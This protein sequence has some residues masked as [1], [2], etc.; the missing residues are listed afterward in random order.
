MSVITIT[1]PG[2]VIN[3]EYY[4]ILKALKDAGIEV[5]EVNV[6]AYETPDEAD[7]HVAII[8]DRLRS[9]DIKSWSVQ[10]EARHLPW[11]G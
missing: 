5:A 7:R 8:G 11:G 2:G 1:G 9:G 10:L 6:C 4:L 3:F